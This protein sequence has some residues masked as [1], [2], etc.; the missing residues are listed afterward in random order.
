MSEPSCVGLT[1]RTS[2]SW[3]ADAVRAVLDPQTRVE[4]HQHGTRPKRSGRRPCTD[5]VA[6]YRLES[7][8]QQFT[9]SSIAPIRSWRHLDR[10][11]AARSM[12]ASSS[13]PCPCRGSTCRQVIQHVHP[14]LQSSG[15][16]ALNRRSTVQPQWDDREAAAPSRQ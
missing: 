12:C 4:T 10:R 9:G 16:Y 3:D 15:W 5:Q 11:V 14:R 7:E 1:T 8:Q 6:F 2:A 13:E